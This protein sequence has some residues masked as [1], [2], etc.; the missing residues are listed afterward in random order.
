MMQARPCISLRFGV[1]RE[2]SLKVSDQTIQPLAVRFGLTAIKGIGPDLAAAITLVRELH[3]PFR[4]LEDFCVRIPPEFLNQRSL[5]ILIKAGAMDSLP[6]TRR[7][8]LAIASKALAL[9]HEAQ[10]ARDRGQV[11]MF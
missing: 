5:E 11:S 3:G 7:Q 8:K 9:A 2:G 4:S 1:I 6:G 10:K